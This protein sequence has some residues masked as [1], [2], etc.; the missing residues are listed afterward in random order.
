[1]T[2]AVAATATA[3]RKSPSPRGLIR[4]VLRVHRPAL[5]MWCAYVLLM[6]G[7][8]LWVHHVSG[9]QARAAQDICRANDGVCVDFDAF[10]FEEGMSMVGAFVAYTSYAVAAWA[11]ASLTGRELESGTARLAWT[12]SVTPA[13]WL[14]VKLAVP[15][16]ALTVGTTVLMLVYRWIWSANEGVRSDEWFYGDPFVNRGPA[17]VAY[18][19]CALAVGALAGLALKRA[20]P[21]L[22][23]ALAFI[24]CFHLYLDERSDTLW[25]A[26]TLTGTTASRLPMSADQ[27]ELGAVT[28]SGARINDL[29]CFDVDTDAGYARCMADNGFTDLYA[30]VHPQSHFWPL[31][32]MTTGLVLAVT[33]LLVLASFHLLRRRTGG[34]S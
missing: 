4:T 18:A 2:T 27:L 1:M 16:V 10:A 17:V 19:L 9:A 12:Q 32:L 26:K 15:A 33:A 30:E 31:H 22:G 7:W 20:L 8:M 11:G 28:G 29:S 3:A 6:T 14:T 24:V 34:T 5:L 13:R 21:A 25:P 23:T